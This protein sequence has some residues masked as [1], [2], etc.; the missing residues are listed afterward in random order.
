MHKLLRVQLPDLQV[1]DLRINFSANVFRVVNK[2]CK[3]LG[4]CCHLLWRY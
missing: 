2:L 1:L 3:E 4:E